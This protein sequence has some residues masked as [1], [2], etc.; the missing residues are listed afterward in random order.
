LIRTVL[1]RPRVD[2]STSHWSL[3]LHADN[4]WLWVCDLLHYL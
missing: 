3:V 4:S 1:I 2:D